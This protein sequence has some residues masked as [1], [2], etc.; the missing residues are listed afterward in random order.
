MS[1]IVVVDVD[2]NVDELEREVGEGCLTLSITT[3]LITTRDHPV[4]LV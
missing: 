2:V 1:D 4:V 3:D